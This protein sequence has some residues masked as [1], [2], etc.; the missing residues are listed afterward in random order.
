MADGQVIGKGPPLRSAAILIGVVV[1]VAG[2]TWLIWVAGNGS[3][4]ESYLANLFATLI[5]IAVAVPIGLGIDR[6][7]QAREAN[8]RRM[9]LLRAIRND[10][11]STGEDLASR[12]DRSAAVVPFLGTGLWEAVSTSGQIK[13]L[14][15]EQ[16]RVVGRAYDRIAVTA[17]LERQLWDLTHDTLHGRTAITPDGVDRD[18]LI[19][20][21]DQDR[22]TTAA[23]EYAIE[24]IAM[25]GS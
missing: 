2:A 22:H 25:G 20:L 5:G 12:T 24:Q 1:V 8:I 18:V 9:H 23:I 19:A 21:S 6:A 10:L 13:D 16:I 11:V 15:P 4:R 17:S 7:A 3:F 14:Q